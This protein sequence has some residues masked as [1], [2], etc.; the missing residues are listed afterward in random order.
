MFS[1]TGMAVLLG[2]RPL[3]DSLLFP[4]EDDILILVFACQTVSAR[5]YHSYVRNDKYI[6]P[7]VFE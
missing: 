3:R 2:V 5:R 7:S 6:K 4:T 1:V